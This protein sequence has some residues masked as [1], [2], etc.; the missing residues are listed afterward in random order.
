MYVLVTS[1]H[2]LRIYFYN[3]GLARF[4]TED[5]SNDANVLK[6]KFEAANATVELDIVDGA[7]INNGA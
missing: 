2:P 1:F 7:R 3:E 5:Y 4:A 6:N